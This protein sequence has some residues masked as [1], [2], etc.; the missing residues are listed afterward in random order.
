[1][2]EGI[3]LSPLE[4]KICWFCHGLKFLHCSYWNFNFKDSKESALKLFFWSIHCQVNTLKRKL[5]DHF[6]NRG[7]IEINEHH[8]PFI[9]YCC[10][11]EFHTSTSTFLLNSYIVELVVHDQNLGLVKSF[12]VENEKNVLKKCSRVSIL[13]F[14]IS[15]TWAIIT[16]QDLLSMFISRIKIMKT[17]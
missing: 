2:E 15:V 16:V 12:L 5:H 8:V 6:I 3:F 7:E 17:K 9:C 14:I 4:K 10:T 13:G 1:M 11:I